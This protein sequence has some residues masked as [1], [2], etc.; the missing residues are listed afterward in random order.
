MYSEAVPV[1][2]IPRHKT[3]MGVVRVRVRGSDSPVV[4]HS[5]CFAMVSSL[6]PKRNSD[7]DMFNQFTNEIVVLE[8]D[9]TRNVGSFGVKLA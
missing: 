2:G 7:K 4:K 9:Q 6:K 3:C 8:G 1:R 5:G